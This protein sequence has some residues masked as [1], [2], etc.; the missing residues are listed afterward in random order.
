METVLQIDTKKLETSLTGAIVRDV[1]VETACRL[2]DCA[3]NDVTLDM[4][5]A[6]KAVNYLEIYGGRL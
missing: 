1:H 4:R 2:F 6:A 5:R 3:P